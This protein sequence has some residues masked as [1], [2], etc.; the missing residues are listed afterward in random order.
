MNKIKLDFVDPKHVDQLMNDKAFHARTSTLNPI[1]HTDN[2]IVV[3]DPVPE[4]SRVDSEIVVLSILAQEIMRVIFPSSI[5]TIRLI[6]PDMTKRKVGL[7][8]G[9]I[10]VIKS[11]TV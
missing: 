10:V 2:S 5:E 3:T 8:L 7:V 6:D 1:K 11:T 4:H 9:K